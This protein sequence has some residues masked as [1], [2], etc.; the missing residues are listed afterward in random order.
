M[1]PLA[2]I[3]RDNARLKRALRL[4]W[5][6]GLIVGALLVLNISVIPPV[7][8]SQGADTFDTEV[9]K[10]ND[11]LRRRRYEDAL[12]TFKRAND[13]RDKKSVECLYGMANAYMGLE[14]YKNVVETC[15][16][17]I[18]LGGDPKN[19]AR[20]YNLEGIALQTQAG[21]K[22]Q[23]KLQEAEAAFRKGLALNSELAIL[24][25]NLGFTLLELGRDAEGIPE[26]KKYVELEP[27]GAKAAEAEK[28][29]ANPRRARE[30][31]APEFSLTTA[32]GEYVSSEDLLGKVVVL[33]FWA[34]WC[35]PCV[36]S[37]PALR[38]LNK[39]F[40]KEP[41]FKM[42]SVSADSDEGKWRGFIE[43]NQLVWTQYID[44]D[45]HVARAFDVHA[46]PT[47]ILIDAEGIIRF[48]EVTSR[49]EQTGDLPEAIKKYLKLAATKTAPAE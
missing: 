11:L 35:P 3:K 25:Y 5:A 10:G 29:I 1:Y 46:Y 2:A 15:E 8:H 6:P 36:D 45:H 47:Y 14:A 27:D 7:A 19:L 41:L 32:D 21:V 43:K 4:V 23:K 40:A 28:L 34:T 44:R 39:R 22:D 30:A 13:M 33:D 12:K 42:I 49:W 31:Y 37:V 9:A 17:L 20:A 38:D 26:L 16:K 48:R 24:H 18:A